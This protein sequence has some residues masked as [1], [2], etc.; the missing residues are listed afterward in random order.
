MRLFHDSVNLRKAVHS[1]LQNQAKFGKFHFSNTD[2]SW[3]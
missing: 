3:Y 2:G 1:S